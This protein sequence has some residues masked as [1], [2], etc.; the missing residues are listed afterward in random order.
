MYVDLTQTHN[1]KATTVKTLQTAKNL[2]E[3]ALVRDLCNHYVA[4]AA[5]ELRDEPEFAAK[6]QPF[7]LDGLSSVVTFS[8]FVALLDTWEPNY[9]SKKYDTVF[10]NMCLILELENDY[11]QVDSYDDDRLIVEINIL[12]LKLDI[13]PIAA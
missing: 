8:D 3:S 13:D 1:R 2:N 7:F 9:S 11:F 12:L 10:Y 6:H 5:D 4:E